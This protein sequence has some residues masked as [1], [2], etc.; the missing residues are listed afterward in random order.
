[1]CLSFAQG[2]T[3]AMTICASSATMQKQPLALSM[4]RHCTGVCSGFAGIRRWAEVSP[5]PN[6]GQCSEPFAMR[7]QM[8]LSA[9]RGA[10][11]R[12]WWWWWSNNSKNLPHVPRC[13]RAGRAQHI[14]RTAHG[15]KCS[16]V[17]LVKV[18]HDNIPAHSVLSTSVPNSHLVG[19]CLNRLS[20]SDLRMSSVAA[21][22]KSVGYT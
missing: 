10:L 20:T 7:T 3:L 13:Y 1:M 5:S 9:L 19:C 12:Y 2:S 17:Q 14:L 8:C 22:W 21:A 18:C 4:A 11:Q 6:R 16:A 15:R